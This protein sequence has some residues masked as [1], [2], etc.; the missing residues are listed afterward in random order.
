MTEAFSLTGTSIT[1]EKGQYALLPNLPQE[2]NVEFYSSTS[3]DTLPV[4]AFVKLYTSSTNTDHPVAA[5][6]AVTDVPYGMVVY[7][8]RKSSYAVGERFAVAQTGDV[9]WCVAESAVDVGDKL[10]F[11]TD[12]TVD[13]TATST[14]AYIGVALTKA[15]AKGDLVQVKLNFNLGVAA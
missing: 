2:H 10:Q 12:W 5:V 8:V 13:D 4:G 15:A 7:D 1:P 11:T 6:C 3:T 9:V 14:Y